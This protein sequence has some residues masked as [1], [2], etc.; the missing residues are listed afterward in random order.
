MGLGTTVH[1]YTGTCMIISRAF[2]CCVLTNVRCL[3]AT[4]NMKFFSVMGAFSGSAKAT[5]QEMSQ[6]SGLNQFSVFDN[7]F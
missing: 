7:K 6:L 5:K 4:F 1:T 2:V 3:F